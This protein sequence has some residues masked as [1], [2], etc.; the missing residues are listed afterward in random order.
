MGSAELDGNGEIGAHAHR[1]FRQAIASR[2]FSGQREMRGRRIVKRRDAHQTGNLQT[3]MV[4][5]AGDK[6]VSLRWSHASLLRLFPSVD[7]DK[8]LRPTI[9]RNDL[10]G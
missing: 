7:L 8:Q 1:Q 6:A 5:A 2:D 9:L 10:L 3:I 4:A